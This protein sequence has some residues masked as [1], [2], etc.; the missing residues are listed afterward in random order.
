MSDKPKPKAVCAQCGKPYRP[1]TEAGL[2]RA[3]K[4]RATDEI[5]KALNLCPDCRRKVAASRL[6]ATGKKR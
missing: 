6:R 5:R 3:Y 2:R 4:N 1:V